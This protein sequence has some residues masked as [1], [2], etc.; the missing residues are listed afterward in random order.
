[1]VNA[2]PE[3]GANASTED[4]DVSAAKRPKKTAKMGMSGI[5]VCPALVKTDTMLSMKRASGTLPQQLQ[6]EF[7]D[8][9]A[10]YCG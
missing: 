7:C 4:E 1:M 9:T 10:P 6:S 3:L 8:L 5:E 2:H